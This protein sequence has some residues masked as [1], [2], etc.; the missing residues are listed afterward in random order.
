MKYS[1]AILVAVGTAACARPK[2]T[3]VAETATGIAPASALSDTALTPPP[4][5]P[6]ET[7]YVARPTPP[8]PPPV[9]VARPG[10]PRRD[11][12]RIDRHARPLVEPPARSAEPIEPM[13]APQPERRETATLPSGTVITATAIDS[14]HSHYNRIGDQIRVRVNADVPS[15]GRPVI[16]AGSVV[17]L[18]IDDIAG[19]PERGRPGTLVLTAHDVD[20]GGTPYPIAATVTDVAAEMKAHGVGASEVAKTAGGAAIGAVLGHIIGGKTG[21]FVGAIGGGAAGA[22][23]AAK[24]ADRDIVVHSGAPVTLQLDAAFERR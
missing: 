10:R 4:P 11:D 13:P 2:S 24:T 23:V 12:R 18:T 16:P 9:A 3:T 7:V 8:P 5:P 15:E 6:P 19:A 22:A 1:I 21:T 14:V 17:T 20:I